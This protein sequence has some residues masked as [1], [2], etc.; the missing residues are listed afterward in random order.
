MLKSVF[1]VTYPCG[2]TDDNHQVKYFWVRSR[3]LSDVK[4]DSLMYHSSRAGGLGLGVFFWQYAEL[5]AVSL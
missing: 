1:L 4:I 5:C 2:R 3:P